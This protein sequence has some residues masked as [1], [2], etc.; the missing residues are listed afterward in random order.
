MV[1]EAG[2]YLSVTA[3]TP[4]DPAIKAIVDPYVSQLAT[5][6]N[7]VVGQT[8]VPIDT[9][10]AYV[11]R[12]PTRRTSRPTP[13]SRSSPATASPTSTSTSRAR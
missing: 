9:T 13:P 12:R 2:Q 4:E 8:T 11:A 5:Y 3:T 6:N 10:S 1:A 7:T